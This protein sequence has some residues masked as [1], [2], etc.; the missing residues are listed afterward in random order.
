MMRKHTPVAPK[1]RR[2]VM[3]NSK[4][5]VNR[6]Y[7]GIMLLISVVVLPVACCICSMNG[8]RSMFQ[9]IYYN[10]KLSVQFVLQKC[11]CLRV[12]TEYTFNKD[13]THMV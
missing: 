2:N 11:G 8:V 6:F 5:R 3:G 1:K 12:N 9:N 10:V 4:E 7:F 13:A